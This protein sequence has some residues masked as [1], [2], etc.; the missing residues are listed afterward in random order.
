MNSNSLTIVSRIQGNEESEMISHDSHDWIRY[1][2]YKEYIYGM[3]LIGY[4]EI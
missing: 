2:I 4:I 3:D 1:F